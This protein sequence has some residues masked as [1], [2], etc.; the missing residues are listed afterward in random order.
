[1]KILRTDGGGEDLSNERLRMVR[2]ILI[3][4]DIKNI[5]LLHDH[6]GILTVFWKLVPNDFEKNKVT[7]IWVT[8][9][10]YEIEHKLVT[11]I[12]L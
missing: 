10:E 12:D 2:N 8:F 4:F 11:Y 9:N 1:M 7:E 3:Y 5:D 6:K